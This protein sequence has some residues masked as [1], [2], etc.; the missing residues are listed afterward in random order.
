MDRKSIAELAKGIGVLIV[1]GGIIFLAFG[2]W[3]W[4]SG[5]KTA[6]GK[7]ATEK[8]AEEDALALLAKEDAVDLLAKKYNAARVMLKRTKNMR[9]T[10]QFEDALAKSEGHP[11]VCEGFLEDIRSQSGGLVAEFCQVMGSGEIRFLLKCSRDQAARLASQK[12]FF[13][14]FVAKILSVE[15]GKVAWGVSGDAPDE[16]RIELEPMIVVR[17]ELVDFTLLSF[18]PTSLESST[19]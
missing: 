14:I 11:V 18:T 7:T 1:I 15:N 10:F 5:A 9:F 19:D 2:G 13:A 6:A 12:L 4:L 16:A 8:F 17:G 3:D